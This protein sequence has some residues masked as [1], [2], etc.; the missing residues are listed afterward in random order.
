M[1]LLVT[2]NNNNKKKI[3][4]WVFYKFNPWKRSFNQSLRRMIESGLVNHYRNQAWRK[5]KR[6]YLNSNE[7][8]IL[9]IEP[10]IIS[11]LPLNALQGGFFFGFLMIFISVFIFIAE[12]TL[13]SSGIKSAQQQK[14]LK[15][16]IST[17][18]KN[19]VTIRVREK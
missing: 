19:I 3:S 8:K 1:F 4:G 13:F 18:E 11:P 6:N 12:L 17:S 16:V 9:H 7:D 14:A 15:T 10:P 2:V 5:M